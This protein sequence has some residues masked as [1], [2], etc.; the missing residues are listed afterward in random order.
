MDRQVR[1]EALSGY[2]RSECDLSRVQGERRPYAIARQHDGRQNREQ[3][4][5]PDR[6]RWQEPHFRC[7]LLF[8]GR[9][10]KEEDT[11][12][13]LLRETIG[14]VRRCGLRSARNFETTG[15]VGRSPTFNRM[16]GFSVLRS[17][18]RLQDVELSISE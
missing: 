17:L 15:N 6:Q 3:W 14:W 13:I 11:R 9:H 8:V 1:R 18:Y 2:R 7:E 5:D 12:E 4:Q 16:W 10:E